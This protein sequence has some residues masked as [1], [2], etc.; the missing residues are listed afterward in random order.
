MYFLTFHN[1]R[2][3]GLAGSS[4]VQSF[5]FIQSRV[6][7]LQRGHFERAAVVAEVDLIVGSALYL[8]PIV[9]PGDGERWGAR[10]FALHLSGCS[11]HCVEI[12]QLP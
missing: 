6:G 11:D 9:V 8:L 10:H 7:Q 3:R 4:L 12:L 2:G 5:A 1:H